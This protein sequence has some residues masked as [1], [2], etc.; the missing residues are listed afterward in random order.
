M[1]LID[2]QALLKKLFPYEVVDKK[3]CAINAYAVERAIMNMPNKL[4]SDEVQKA[5]NYIEKVLDNWNEFC[6]QHPQ[7]AKALEVLLEVVKDE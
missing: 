2:R 7:F 4:N 3:N 5:T 6:N 1:D